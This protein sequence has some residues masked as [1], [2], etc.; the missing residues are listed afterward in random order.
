[1]KKNTNNRNMALF[2]LKFNL[3]RKLTLFLLVI[4]FFKIQASTTDE[5]TKITLDLNNVTIERVLSKIEAKTDFKFLFNRSD[6]DINKLVSIRAKQQTIKN[7]LNKIF[8][9]MPI[10]YQLQDKQIILSSNKTKEGGKNLEID[11]QS[12]IKG[13]V[14]DSNGMSIPGVTVIVMSTKVGTSTDFDGNYTIRAKKGDVLQFS[15][16]GM[17]TIK[18][19][20]G[21]L[22]NINIVMQDEAQGLNEVVVTAFGIQRKKNIL[23]YAA[24]QID[25]DDVNKTKGGNIASGLSGKISGLQISQGNA[26]GGSV[27]VVI[28]GAKSLTGN[29]QALFV[30]DGVPV[31]N[32]NTN[33][34]AQQTGG[35][36]YDYG[37]AAADI[38]PNDIESINVLKGAAA[39][40]LYGSRAANGVVMITTKKAKKGINISVNSALLVGQIDK[41]TFVNYQQEYGAGRSAEY[42]RNGFLLFDANA[43]G[44]DDLVV[45]TFAPRSWGPRYDP[46]L[47]VYDWESFDPSSPS[48]RQPKPWAMPENGPE[49][50]YETSVSS[51]Q[52]ILIDGLIADKGS[53]KFGYTRNDE[54]GTVPN[55][56]VLKNNYSLNGTYNLKSNL[57]L[58]ATVNFSEIVGKGRYGTGYDSGRNV[59]STFRHFNQTNYD[60]QEQK[61]AYFR[62]RRNITWNWADPTTPEGIRPAFSNN[63]YWTIYENYEND[64]RSRVIAN[65]FLSYKVTDWLNVLGRMSI[66]TYSENQQQRV[67]VGS[68]GIPSYSRFDRS[69]KETNYD[70]LATVDKKLSEDFDLNALAGMNIRKNTISSV[71]SSTSGGLVIPNFYAISNSLGTVPAP[72]E[73]YQPKAV[74]GY[75]GGTTLTYRDFLTLDATLRRD[76]SSTLPS[77]DNAYNYYAVSSSWLF[78]HHLE[79]LGWLS[80][81]K[82]RANY[83]TVG[84]DAPWGSLTDVY[85]KP[86]PFGSGLLFS[87][88]NTK[89]NGN[90]KPEMT[91]SREIGLEMSFLN[92]R[93]GF[94]ASY[95]HT[96][97]VDQIIPVAVS[98]ATGYSSKF[99]NAGDI[100]NKGVELSLFGAPIRN[101]NF[102]WNVNVNFSRNR[103][104]VLSLYEDSTNLQLASFQGGVSLNASVGRP[105]GELQS[106]T[107]EYL[108]GERVVKEN[109]LWKQSSS[110]S[111]IIGN[112]NPDWIGGINNTFRYKDLT[113][114]F[115]IDVRKGGDLF[116]LDMYYGSAAGLYPRTAGLNDLG[117]PVRDAV[118]NGGGV[119]LPGV[120]ADGSPNTKR[121]TITS[122]NSFY[123]P[124]SEFVYDA[125][126]VKLRELSLSYSL[127]KKLTT[128]YFEDIELSLIGRNLWIIHK[129]VPYAD[130]EENLSSGNVQGYQSGSYPTTRTIGFN[131]KL[132]I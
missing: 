26:V 85:D 95:Y 106:Y 31:D 67:A 119:I 4:S 41:S 113:L 68:A 97:T 52:S 118:A 75:F 89:N 57:T 103:N 3:K 44:M 46:N 24:Q 28:R 93:F 108:N 11:Q 73:S 30:V 122:N 16:L 58:G 20:V 42:G 76:I 13:V 60:I 116:S 63:P 6:V 34:S 87:V 128:K 61:D 35:G 82:I 105:Y 80:S 83:A 27:N 72:I 53:I 129:N 2:H 88:P 8:L 54:R 48:Y 64:T 121:V 22:N 102:S 125:S 81:G 120:T 77:D 101:R 55:S 109:G 7:I 45:P 1:M 37:N 15:F 5:S 131:V 79:N 12:E 14:S 124:Q 123:E 117:N 71:F 62:T 19:T 127:P 104:K 107:Y 36:G 49:T 84:N 33:T 78:S 50:F 112:I 132:K 99:I 69:Y 32:S 56:R 100:E 38:N 91:V 66:D 96:N 40:A 21:T 43:D 98:V 23:P 18:A 74:D 86:N 65:T 111:N 9:G 29:N 90:L 92:N 17:K 70:L 51:T 94:D 25:G 59:N 110:T 39:S 10:S 47:L 130:P 114:S 115:L 126:Y